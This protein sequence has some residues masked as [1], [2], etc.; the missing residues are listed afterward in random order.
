MPSELRDEHASAAP[1]APDLLDRRLGADEHALGL[2]QGSRRRASGV[3]A[4]AL[5][6]TGAHDGAVGVED[7]H[8]REPVR[9]R[10]LV[11]GAVVGGDDHTDLVVQRPAGQHRHL[12]VGDRDD[13]RRPCERR[14]D[15]DGDRD[16]SG[17]QLGFE[18]DEVEV[19]AARRGQANGQRLSPDLAALGVDG[20]DG[21]PAPWTG[22]DDA[23]RLFDQSLLVEADEGGA[24]GGG[25]RR[26]DRRGQA[27]V[28]RHRE[29]GE[30][31]RRG[32][33]PFLLERSGTRRE[34]VGRQRG[35]VVPLARQLLVERVL[36]RRGRR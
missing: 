25:D 8:R 32:N 15:R 9:L 16:G 6:R 17:Q 4:K 24:G 27:E 18:D 26:R 34:L 12:P 13:D 14:P 2:E 28:G 21:G 19:V 33:P 31:V 23:L 29:P 35:A 30:Q 5:Q 10:K 3:A 7:G 20:V 11:V 36:A 22:R 1:A